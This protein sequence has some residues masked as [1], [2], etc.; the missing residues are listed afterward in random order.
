MFSTALAKMLASNNA[1][2]IKLYFRHVAHT[3]CIQ[4]ILTGYSVAG[5]TSP[6]R[7]T[8]RTGT[9]FLVGSIKL[10]SFLLRLQPC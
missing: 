8:I 3:K 6:V 9:V 10:S 4:W 1:I 5:A 2:I 7:C